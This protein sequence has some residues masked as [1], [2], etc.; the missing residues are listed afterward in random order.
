MSEATKPTP[1]LI[2]AQRISEGRSLSGFT[3]TEITAGTALHEHQEEVRE[4]YRRML[5][6][7]DAPPLPPVTDVIRRILAASERA[8]A[9]GLDLVTL[10]PADATRA[11]LVA[12]GAIMT[13]V[14]HRFRAE[15]SDMIELS[16][17]LHPYHSEGRTLGEAFAEW[18]AAQRPERS[19][20]TPGQ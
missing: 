13:A 5:E 11:D 14:G 20:E 12:A 3:P 9:E 16:H 15:G 17:M 2:V 10:L 6:E 4:L 8:E 18:E 7:D 19:D 1:A